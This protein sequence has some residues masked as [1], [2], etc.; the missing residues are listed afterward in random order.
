MGCVLEYDGPDES[1]ESIDEYIL[2]CAEGSVLVANHGG[3]EDA[4]V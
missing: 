1:D 2:V 4:S 3:L